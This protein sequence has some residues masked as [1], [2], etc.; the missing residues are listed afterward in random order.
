M[1]QI[2]P[3]AMFFKNIANISVTVTVTVSVTVQLCMHPLSFMCMLNTV[4]DTFVSF[5]FFSAAF[6]PLVAKNG[7]K[8]V[9]N[10]NFGFLIIKLAYVLLSWQNKLI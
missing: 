6:H 9:K 10:T 4:F 8:Q 1:P 3:R 5:T 7:S 2:I